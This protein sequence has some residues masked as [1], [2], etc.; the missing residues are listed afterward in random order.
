MV[1]SVSTCSALDTET[2]TRTLS[3]NYTALF[4]GLNKAKLEEKD[5]MLGCR[6]T[7]EVKNQ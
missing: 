5:I 4:Q 1:T 7:P 6:S 3:L 2:V